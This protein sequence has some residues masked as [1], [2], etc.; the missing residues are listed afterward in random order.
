MYTPLPKY[1]VEIKGSTALQFRASLRAQGGVKTPPEEVETRCRAGWGSLIKASTSPWADLDEDV[2]VGVGDQ[3]DD[4]PVKGDVQDK[5]RSGK[6]VH[7][8]GTWSDRA[9]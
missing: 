2:E 7:V 6:V 5:L 4:S 8:E 3:H 9:W 1:K